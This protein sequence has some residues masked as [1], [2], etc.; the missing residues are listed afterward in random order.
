MYVDS[1]LL[2]SYLVNTWIGKFLLLQY[3]F[4]FVCP[5]LIQ[6]FSDTPDRLFALPSNS[7]RG[8]KHQ[9]SDSLTVALALNHSSI[10]CST[11]YIL[12]STVEKK[13]KLM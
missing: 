13:R 10:F 2:F 1:I 9:G 7:V 3:H 5:G 8:Q 11:C 12:P 4:T 6:T